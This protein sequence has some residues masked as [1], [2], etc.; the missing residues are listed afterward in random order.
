MEEVSTLPVGCGIGRALSGY[1]PRACVRS[2]G[3][4]SAASTAAVTLRPGDL[5]GDHA[6]LVVEVAAGG[7]WYAVNP[8]KPEFYVRRGASTAP[9]RLNEIESGFG[10]QQGRIGRW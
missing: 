9:A 10:Y 7:R 1:G 2:C 3:P 5:H 8:L 6:A 4:A